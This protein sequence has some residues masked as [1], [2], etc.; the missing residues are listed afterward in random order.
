MSTSTSWY[1]MPID[2]SVLKDLITIN[3]INVFVAL[4]QAQHFN[5]HVRSSSEILF[6]SNLKD[7]LGT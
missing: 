5:G 3:V 7:F 4:Y 6:T 1:A 2:W